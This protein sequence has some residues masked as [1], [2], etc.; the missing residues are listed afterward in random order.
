MLLLLARDLQGCLAPDEASSHCIIK[1]GFLAVRAAPLLSLTDAGCNMQ[2]ADFLVDVDAVTHIA[3]SL[4][5]R[6]DMAVV[7]CGRQRQGASNNTQ[8]LFETLHG[9]LPEQLVRRVL[10]LAEAP[11]AQLLL[12]LP[13]KLWS[14]AAA[15]RVLDGALELSYQLATSPECAKTV[16]NQLQ[17]P[18]V[19]AA[20]S[21]V[22]HLS[23]AHCSMQPAA[24]LAG[25]PLLR[26]T[27]GLQT[28]DLSYNKLDAS[29]LEDLAQYFSQLP[30]LKVRCLLLACLLCFRLDVAAWLLARLPG[31]KPSLSPD[32]L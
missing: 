4:G 12:C 6:V 15:S 26:S 19:G 8:Q 10:A 1:G 28:L 22:L 3:A 16:M 20:L 7:R 24:L 29:S 21:H 25:L 5:K 9:K 17:A 32:E 14:S 11:L 30:E 13:R 31:F 27:R 23:F 18:A 2:I